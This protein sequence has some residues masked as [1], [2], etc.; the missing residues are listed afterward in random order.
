MLS[1]G[2]L[3]VEYGHIETIQDVEALIAS[4][5]EPIVRVAIIWDSPLSALRDDLPGALELM[6]AKGAALVSNVTRLP[7]D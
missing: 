6:R 2:G 3:P 4:R 1:P 7:S 5:K